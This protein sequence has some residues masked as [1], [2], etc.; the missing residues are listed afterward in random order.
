MCADTCGTIHDIDDCMSDAMHVNEVYFQHNVFTWMDRVSRVQNND[1]I[2]NLGPGCFLLE[3]D[4]KEDPKCL[5]CFSR[6][7][8][9]ELSQLT[10]LLSLNEDSAATKTLACYFESK[11]GCKDLQLVHDLMCDFE[12]KNR[13]IANFDLNQ[14]SFEGEASSSGGDTSKIKKPNVGT[15]I[16]I[17]WEI[18]DLE[19]VREEAA[20]A[21]CVICL[22]NKRKVVLISVLRRYVWVLES[23]QASNCAECVD[24]GINGPQFPYNQYLRQIPVLSALK[25]LE[26][27]LQWK[28]ESS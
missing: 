19:D 4:E 10:Y 8:K 21:E 28:R 16:S 23:E 12:K 9:W 22:T 7:Q 17:E 2:S 3:I 11:S 18:Y 20:F 24:K 14:V 5:K 15:V 6:T 26:N 13:M 25:Y 27:S 1:Y